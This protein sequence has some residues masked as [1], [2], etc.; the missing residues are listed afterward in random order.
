MQLSVT[1]GDSV[2]TSY[3]VS[4]GSQPSADVTVTV[5][6]G[7]H[8]H[9]DVTLSPANVLT[10]TASGLEQ[11]SDR[12][13]DRHRGRRRQHR[14]LRSISPTRP[15]ATIRTYE[16]H[17][18]RL[19]QGHRQR[20]GHRRDHR[21]R[22]RS[23]TVAEIGTGTYTVTLSH[24]PTRRRDH[25]HHRQLRHCWQ[26]RGDHQS[27]PAHLRRVELERSRGPGRQGDRRQRR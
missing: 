9:S 20:K 16:R 19:G 18:Y 1:E 17:Q 7:G 15:P 14:R 12:D 24:P 13:G 3:E 4:L 8:D 2:G 22:P 26:L 21:V 11:R 10:F 25:R 6:I 23:W 27:H 5:A